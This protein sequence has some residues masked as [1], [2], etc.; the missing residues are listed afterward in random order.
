[1]IMTILIA[2]ALTLTASSALPTCDTGLD[3]NV[4]MGRSNKLASDTGSGKDALD[5]GTTSTLTLTFQFFGC[6]TIPLASDQSP[7]PGLQLGL[8][9]DDRNP[10]N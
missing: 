6:R 7:Q 5:P 4:Y 3:N 2:S 8:L 1:M 10:N 9:T